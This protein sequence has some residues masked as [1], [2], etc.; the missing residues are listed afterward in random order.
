MKYL[1]LFSLQLCSLSLF[2]QVK[3]VDGQTYST[4]VIGNQTWTSTNLNV[5][6]FRNGDLIPQAKT[7]MEWM[8]ANEN[9]QPAWC[10]YQNKSKFGKQFGKLYN[11]FALMDIRGIAPEGFHIPTDEEWTTLTNFTNA[12]DATKVML[13]KLGLN[14]QAGGYR[15]DGGS[16][17][18]MNVSSYWWSQTEY[19]ETQ[20]ALL[21]KMESNTDTLGGD[22]HG[23]DWGFYIRCV[24]D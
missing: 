13:N 6:H 2:G 9:Q 4:V 1:F 5:S 8:V 10:Y 3:D 22:M 19:F 24:K 15:Y 18:G 16:F 20:N 14:L 21:R 12:P 23:Y 11:G 7:P 17:E